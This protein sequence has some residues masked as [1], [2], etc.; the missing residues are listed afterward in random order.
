[1]PDT[2]LLIRVGRQP[3]A[4]VS[5]LMLLTLMLAGCSGGDFGRTREDFRND[6]MHRW[7]GTEATGS[8]G[9]YASQFQ[10][11]DGE[12]QLRDQAYP[13][14]EPP[15]SR[16][17]W[18]A[19]FGEYQVVASPWREK[20]AVD[21]RYTRRHHPLRAVLFHRWPGARPRPQAQCQPCSCLAIVAARARGR[22][23]PHGREHADRA[24]G[25]AMPGAAN[26]V[27]PLGAGAAGGPGARRHGRGSRP[28]SQRI[29]HFGR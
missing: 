13:V 17:A 23:R 10:L 3:S 9:L 5:A 18:K 24:M 6:D 11:T 12:R 1:M 8:V 7:L 29:G 15:H 25:P 26:F 19:V 16:P 28:A 21:R 4:S 27:V 14:I 22:G 2:S 20:F